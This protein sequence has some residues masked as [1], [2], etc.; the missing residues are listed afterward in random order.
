MIT[1]SANGHNITRNSSRFK[2]IPSDS[3]NS[4]QRDNIEEEDEKDQTPPNTETTATTPTS[5]PHTLLT[6]TTSQPPHTRPTRIR[7]PPNILRTMWLNRLI[8]S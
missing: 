3:Y 7:K 1:A 4:Y 5:L 6:Q 2:G 8:Y